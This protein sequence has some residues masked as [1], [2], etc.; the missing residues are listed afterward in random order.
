MRQGYL[1]FT[2]DYAQLKHMGYTFH[3]LFA[4]NIMT[5]NR[6]D[7]G[8]WIRKR[9]GYLYHGNLDLY[10]LIAFLKTNPVGRQH[11]GAIT[12]YK[13]YTVG[14]VRTADDYDRFEYKE[15]SDEN[16]KY[17]AECIKRWGDVTDDTPDSELPPYVTHEAFLDDL[18]AHLDELEKLGWYELVV[19]NT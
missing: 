3:K 5:W 16:Q 17:Y 4:D 6:D 15:T 8:L 19:N 13:F 2:G 11:D 9:G 7:L 12:Y 1:K 18:V 14:A 10:K